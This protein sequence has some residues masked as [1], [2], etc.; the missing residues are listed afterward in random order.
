M[1][2]EGDLPPFH[3]A[4]PCLDVAEAAAFYEALGC[5]VGR[6]NDHAAITT[7][8]PP[9]PCPACRGLMLWWDL[10]GGVHCLECDPPIKS[11]KLMEVRERVLNREERRR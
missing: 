3:L 2:S 10:G 7:I 1:S 4:F 11:R 9:A 8:D 6:A 5:T